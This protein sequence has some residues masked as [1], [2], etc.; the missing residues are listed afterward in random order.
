MFKFFGIKAKPNADAKAQTAHEIAYGLLLTQL[1]LGGAFDDEAAKQ[2]LLAPRGCGYIFGFADALLQ[3]AGVTDE[4]AAMAALV[5]TYVRIFGKEQGPKIFRAALDLQTD[6]DFAAGRA[7]GDNDA[8]RFLADNA[9]PLG[10]TDYLND[11]P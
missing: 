9:P 7:Q 1:D 3:R 2:R 5:V 10:L 8:L 4:V 11:R 6:A